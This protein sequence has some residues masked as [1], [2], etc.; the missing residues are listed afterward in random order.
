MSRLKHDFPL[1]RPWFA[2]ALVWICCLSCRAN[3]SPVAV[4]GA[5]MDGGGVVSCGQ[6]WSVPGGVGVYGGVGKG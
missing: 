2:V 6:A 3:S 1:V 5:F 4:V